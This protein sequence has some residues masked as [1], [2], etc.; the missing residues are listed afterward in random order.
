VSSFVRFEEQPGRV[1]A[2][3]KRVLVTSERAGHLLGVIGWY[4]PW[5]QYVFEPILGTIWSD[6]CLADVRAKVAAL[7]AEQRASAERRRRE[8]VALEET[9]T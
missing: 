7:N 8:R 6:G 3:T 2:T 5:R 9:T 1:G 4:G